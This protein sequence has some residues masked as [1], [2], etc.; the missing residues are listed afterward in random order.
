MTRFSEV[1][2]F[3]VQLRGIRP[4]VWRRIQMPA[5]CTFWD[6][7]C[8]IQD[9]MGWEDSHL[10]EFEVV[11][12]QT[13]NTEVIGVPEPEAWRPVKAGWSQKVRKYLGAPGSRASY[14]YD[15]GDEWDH[16]VTLQKVLPKD[17]EAAYPRCVAGKRACPPEDCGGVWGYWEI[18]SGLSEFQEEYADFDPE[19]FHPRDVIFDDPTARREWMERWP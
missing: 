5:T 14:L 2:E 12:P 16:S 6:L 7:H 17:R 1:L 18:L 10:H 15:F 4:P 19:A 11:H 8:A 9:A 13:G 3:K